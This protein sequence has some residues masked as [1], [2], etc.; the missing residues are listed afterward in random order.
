MPS[1]PRLLCHLLLPLAAAA[2][3]AVDA[4]GGDPHGDGGAAGPDGAGGPDGP[5][6][7][8][9]ADGGSPHPGVDGGVPPAGGERIVGYFTAWSVYGRDYHVPDIPA[10]S[11]THVNYAFANISAEGTCALG[12]PYA[13]IDKFYPG[14]SWDAGALRGSFHQLTLLK[15]AHPH[16]RTLISVGGW[17]WSGRF[18]DVAAT[19][20]ARQ[21]FASSCVDFMVR[22]GFDGIDIDWEYPVGGGLEGNTTRPEDRANYTLLLSELRAR[23]DQRGAED[24][25]HYLLTIAAPAGPS[26]MPHIDMVGI[27]G[28]V[29]WI[30]LMTYDFHGGWSALTGFNAPLYPSPTD[31]DD[32]RLNADSAVQAYLDAGVPAGQLVLGVP[33]YGRGWA[34]VGATNAGRFQP[35]AG[36]PPGTWEPGS[37]D[38][39][40]LVQN[41]LPSYQRHV[42]PDARVP[43][44]YS[45][46]SQVMI[47]YDD[48]ESLAAKAAYAAGRGLGGVMFWELSCDDDQGSLIRALA[49]R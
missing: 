5:G 18:S 13:D 28:A 3:C 23:L 15:A 6:G 24:G 2:G 4:I 16:L 34:G 41:Y 10:D 47:S 29:D 1:F 9:G 19:P 40:D 31:P 37:F 25:T 21:T 44:L 12:D 17:T 42:D 36:T 11:L 7:P 26:T 45:P 46:T 20:A 35:H 22:Y 32:Q 49:P 14:D 30:N 43:W 27:A 33:F 39:Q 48:P 8:G 38:Y